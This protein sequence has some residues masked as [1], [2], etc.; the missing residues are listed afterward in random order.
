MHPLIYQVTLVPP[1]GNG[2][3]STRLVPG[4]DSTLQQAQS[5]DIAVLVPRPSRLFGLIARSSVVIGT[6]P[7]DCAM[8]VRP[9]LVAGRRIRVRIVDMRGPPRAPDQVV[10]SVWTSL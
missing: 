7:V 10:I 9:F 6:L 1:A 8:I 3:V 5:G 4:M 2:L